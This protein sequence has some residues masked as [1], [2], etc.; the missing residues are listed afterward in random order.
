MN[1]GVSAPYIMKRKKTQRPEGLEN[2][3]PDPA[4]E[5]LFLLDD[6][7][8]DREISRLASGY[9]FPFPLPLMN[10]FIFRDLAEKR[11]YCR[12]SLGDLCIAEQIIPDTTPEFYRDLQRFLARRGLALI[13]W[14]CPQD[15]GPDYTL[16]ITVKP[17]LTREVLCREFS[18]AVRLP[19]ATD[20]DRS[21]LRRCREALASYR[22]MLG[23]LTRLHEICPDGLDARRREL[24]YR[25]IACRPL[26]AAGRRYLQ[27][28]FTLTCEFG[29]YRPRPGAQPHPILAAAITRDLT[30]LGAVGTPLPFM[31]PPVPPKT[32]PQSDLLGLSAAAV[33]PGVAFTGHF[34]LTDD[35]EHTLAAAVAAAP[36]EFAALGAALDRLK[37]EIP[38]E[39]GRRRRDPP[40]RVGLYLTTADP[41]AHALFAVVINPEDPIVRPSAPE[42]KAAPQQWQPFLFATYILGQILLPAIKPAALPRRVALRTEALR[43]MFTAA[44]DELWAVLCALFQAL[45]AP[46]DRLPKPFSWVIMHGIVAAP[47]ILRFWIGKIGSPA[48]LADA[49]GRRL[50]ALY[51]C[52]RA[53]QASPEWASRSPA[54]R[55]FRAALGADLLQEYI[56]PGRDDT[57]PPDEERSCLT[58]GTHPAFFRMFFTPLL[59]AAPDPTRAYA[60]P[61]QLI[62]RALQGAGE[63]LRYQPASRYDEMVAIIAGC[64]DQHH[65]PVYYR[66]RLVKQRF[67]HPEEAA[68]D[69]LVYVRDPEVRLDCLYNVMS[70]LNLSFSPPPYLPV[71]LPDLSY[72]VISPWPHE[73]RRPTACLRECGAIILALLLYRTVTRTLPGEADCRPMY[74]TAAA[75]LVPGADRAGT[76]WCRQYCHGVLTILPDYEQIPP[77]LWSALQADL[78][79]H[80]QARWRHYLRFLHR[81]TSRL[82]QL[83]PLWTRKI[84]PR[85]PL[86]LPG[87]CLDHAL[88][89]R[90]L[91]ESAE[92]ATYINAMGNEE[93][94]TAAVLP[95][96]AADGAAA[97]AA[98]PSSELHALLQ[99]LIRQGAAELSQADF[100]A[101]CASARFLSAAA[102][103]EEANTRSYA[104]CDAALLEEDPESGQIYVQTELLGRCS[105][106]IVDDDRP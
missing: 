53:L 30:A 12:L 40:Q 83:V 72:A 102:A 82:P 22:E 57:R 89:T 34:P 61:D 47:E 93:T 13:P 2:L 20:Q 95:P 28:C 71:S 27:T 39:Y 17:D 55:I 29:P 69:V 35:Q 33:A 85:H 92:A 42:D 98:P 63:A 43:A 9:S 105:S 88:I 37:V 1:D 67:S 8:H 23:V 70:A 46:V 5:R 7:T 45:S 19:G 14:F 11:E 103:L 48:L 101:L 24:L 106:P 21:A 78:V 74:H 16:T 56:R 32:A 25:Q 41:Q 15:L 31:P 79:C 3:V 73:N 52:I 100:A 58:A 68:W 6:R 97:A 64:Q 91:Q 36:D 90:R 38:V 62:A 44:D 66:S 87:L 65:S 94:A 75:A 60:R 77:A 81:R 80:P 50:I 49:A 99:A 59:Y 51:F 4:R 10:L 26:P 84:N 76:E 96:T 86:P 104:L 54:D 18:P